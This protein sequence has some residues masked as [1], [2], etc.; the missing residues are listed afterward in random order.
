VG[1]NWLKAHAD[2]DRKVLL[3]TYTALQREETDSICCSSVRILST[4]WANVKATFREAFWSV[5]NLYSW[6]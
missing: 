3:A 6:A 4:M 1:M 2:K 5:V